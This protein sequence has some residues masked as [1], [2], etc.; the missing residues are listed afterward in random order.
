MLPPRA[1][2]ASPNYRR[3][4]SAHLSIGMAESNEEYQHGKPTEGMCCLCTMED[5]TEEDQNYGEKKREGE[6]EDENDYFSFDTPNLIPHS[7]RRYHT[8]IIA[9]T[10]QKSRISVISIN[11]MAGCTI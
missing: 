8:F 11:A 1:A 5:I 10:I 6:N 7:I 9:T 2:Q 4:F 3:T